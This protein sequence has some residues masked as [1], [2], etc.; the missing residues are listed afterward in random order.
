MDTKLPLFANIYLRYLKKSF[1]IIQTLLSRF[2]SFSSAI[3]IVPVILVATLW[4][5]S[6]FAELE[7]C[8]SHRNVTQVT[9]RLQSTRGLL[10]LSTLLIMYSCNILLFLSCTLVLVYCL[11]LVS[12][13]CTLIQTL[14]KTK[15]LQEQ[16][17]WQN[18]FTQKCA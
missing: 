7:T 4:N 16:G 5:I 2:R 3:Y 17:L 1:L 11:F 14:K 10:N 18:N 12:Y 9:D 8:Y 6:R 13:P 15:N